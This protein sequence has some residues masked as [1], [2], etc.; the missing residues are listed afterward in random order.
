MTVTAIH[1]APARAATDARAL[2]SEDALAAVTATVQSD[3]A[4]M[5]KDRASRIVVEALKFVATAAKCPESQMRPSKLV[6]M[7]WHALILH[8]A[9]YAELCARLGRF[10]HHIPDQPPSA[11]GGTGSLHQTQDLM[12]A[13]GYPPDR[14]LWLRSSGAAECEG[15]PAPCCKSCGPQR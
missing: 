11:H 1:A 5:D 14:T 3:N 9:R 6:D 10:V 4:P 2:L 13:A 8:T 12:A 7:G 15:G